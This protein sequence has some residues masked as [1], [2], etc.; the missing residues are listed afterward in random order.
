MIHSMLEGGTSVVT[1]KRY[2][3]QEADFM[4]FVGR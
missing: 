4:G 2:L 1:Y 3:V